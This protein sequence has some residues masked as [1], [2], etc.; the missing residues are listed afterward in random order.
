[1]QA[2]YDESLNERKLFENRKEMIKT[3]LERA[4]E[5]TKALE[6]EKVRWTQQYEEL[7]HDSSSIIG[8][9]LI[10]AASVN[11]LGALTQ[12]FMFILS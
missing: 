2:K 10:Y 5:L 7:S 4:S 8:T 1:M 11:Y 9:S 3:R 12:V 6:T